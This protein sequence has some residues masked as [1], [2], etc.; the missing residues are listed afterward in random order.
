MSHCVWSIVL[1]SV[2]LP[3]K[4]QISFCM[5]LDELSP[6]WPVEHHMACWSYRCSQ[7]FP[8]GVAFKSCNLLAW[9]VWGCPPVAFVPLPS[10]ATWSSQCLGYCFP[11][12]WGEESWDSIWC[13]RRGGRGAGFL[14]PSLVITSFLSHSWLLLNLTGL[15]WGQLETQKRHQIDR[16]KV[17]SGMLGAWVEMPNP[18]CFS[19]LSLRKV[20]LLAVL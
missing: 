9:A 1:F 5:V 8:L 3:Q 17:A 4:V 15:N 16:Q 6:G 19:S 14:A 10:L 2:S 18:N 11:L 13:C 20:L 7:S 12:G